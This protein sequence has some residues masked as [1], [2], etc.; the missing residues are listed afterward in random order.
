SHLPYEFGGALTGGRVIVPER[1]GGRRRAD[2]TGIP[3]GGPDYAHAPVRLLAAEVAVFL[4][5]PRRAHGA[6]AGI[7]V[8]QFLANI[9]AAPVR[10]PEPRIMREGGVVPGG[11]AQDGAAPIAG[12]GL[13]V[14]DVHDH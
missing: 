12:H 4:A 11:R 6:L 7:A 2:F 5:M 10:A 3:D 13:A 9:L 14:A 8:A 1:D